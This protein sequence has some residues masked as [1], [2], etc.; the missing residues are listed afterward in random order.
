QVSRRTADPKPDAAHGGKS[1]WV[2]SANNNEARS[3]CSAFRQPAVRDG[4]HDEDRREW[5]WRRPGDGRESDGRT[6]SAPSREHPECRGQG[7]RVDA[8]DCN[9]RSTAEGRVAGGPQ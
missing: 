5:I 8:R 3:T 4:T 7:S 9:A 1:E 6:A 2:S